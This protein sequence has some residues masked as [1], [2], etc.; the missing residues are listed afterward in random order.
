[1]GNQSETVAMSDRIAMMNHGRA[2]VFAPAAR[3]CLRA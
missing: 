2:V 1:V 3:L